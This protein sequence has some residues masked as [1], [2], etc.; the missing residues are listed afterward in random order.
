VKEFLCDV[1]VVGSGPAGLAA[2]AAA[3]K[4]GAGKVLIIERDI[5]IGGI[6]QQCIHPGFGLKYFDEELTGP[7]YAQRFF[8]KAQSAGVEWLLD[9]TALEIRGKQL[10][11]VNRDGMIII[12]FGALILAM[13][14]RE[15]TRANLAI[16]G[17][18]PAGIYTAGTAQKLI[19]IYGLRIGK[20]VVILGSGDIGMIMARRL[21]LEGANVKAVVEL[22]PYLAGLTRNKVQC[23]DDFEIPLLLSHTIVDITGSDRIESV[24]VAPVD[25]EKHP[26]LERSYVVPCDT[27]LLSVGLI[28]ENELSNTGNV[29]L[30]NMTNGAIVNQFMQTDV[31][32]V[33]ACGNVLHVHDLVDN[34]SIE[35]ETAGASAARYIAG[36]LP[37]GTM[38]DIVPGSGIRQV[39]P[40]KIAPVGND[41]IALYF[42]VAEPDSNICITA[43]AGQRILAT[44][45]IPHISPGTMEKLILS[46]EQLTSLKETVVVSTE[47]MEGRK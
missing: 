30:S 5:S 47:H 34:V 14:C 27:L 3:R 45:C 4:T 31:P 24:T 38:I 29:A 28:P 7:E 19:N 37:V 2:A 23:L 36:T 18:R 35:S 42:R 40:Q 32:Y 41:G 1:A 33:F 17:S 22:M 15:R 43:C 39:C 10:V 16:P 12:N 46:V 25:D 6:L 44:R 11:C 26:I 13:G 9:T 20:D 8:N 21:T